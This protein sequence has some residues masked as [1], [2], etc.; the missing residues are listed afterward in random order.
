MVILYKF[1]GIW[2]MG[3]VNGYLVEEIPILSG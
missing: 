1:H 2:L 3:L